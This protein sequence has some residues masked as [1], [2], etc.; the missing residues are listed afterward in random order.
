MYIR[1]FPLLLFIALI[2]CDQKD[3][4]IEYKD[5]VRVKLHKEYCGQGILEIIDPAHFD[6]GQ[7]WTD[8][9]GVEY[10]NVFST[11]LPCTAPGREF[12][13]QFADS[14]EDNGCAQCLALLIGPEKFSHIKVITNC[15]E[16][17]LE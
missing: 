12:Y 10:R 4:C 14:Q 1:I 17:E 2:S 5:C 8:P 15:A 11:V 9:S 3:E 7:N 6:K 16:E 13:I